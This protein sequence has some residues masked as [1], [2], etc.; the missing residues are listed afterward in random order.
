ME[1]GIDKVEKTP[2]SIIVKVRRIDNRRSPDLL[3]KSEHEIATF[4]YSVPKKR[5]LSEFY[6]ISERYGQRRP[7]SAV[8]TRDHIK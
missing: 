8:D 3:I 5:N 1:V 6:Q 2:A 7:E 4:D